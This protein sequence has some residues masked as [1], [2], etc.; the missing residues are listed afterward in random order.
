MGDLEVNPLVRS[1][2]VLHDQVDPGLPPAKSGREGQ[3]H[4]RG[5]ETLPYGFRRQGNEGPRIESRGN[6]S[7]KKGLEDLSHPVR[8]PQRGLEKTVMNGNVIHQSP[9]SYQLLETSGKNFTHYPRTG[10]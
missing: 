5:I 4:E 7:R 2:L 9:L 8:S 1:A 10:K 6:L 3:V